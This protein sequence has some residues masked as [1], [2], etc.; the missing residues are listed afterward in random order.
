MTE[1]KGLKGK[2]REIYLTGSYYCRVMT[3]FHSC[4]PEGHLSLH[5]SYLSGSP[6]TN[7]GPV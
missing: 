1:K 4:D 2:R 5:F 7:Y 6:V 3:Q